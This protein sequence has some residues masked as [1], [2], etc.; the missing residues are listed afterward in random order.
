MDLQQLY[1]L[2]QRYRMQLQGVTAAG[3]DRLLAVG[4]LSGPVGGVAAAGGLHTAPQTV[5]AS[6][7][8]GQKELLPLPAHTATAGDEC[9]AFGPFGALLAGGGGSG[10]RPNALLAHCLERF[11]ADALLAA[12]SARCPPP[13]L[14]PQPQT[15]LQPLTLPLPPAP[16]SHSVRSPLSLPGPVPML[17]PALAAEPNANQTLGLMQY[18][19]AL[20]ARCSQSNDQRVEASK[21]QQMA[22][23]LEG[24]GFSGHSSPLNLS[25]SLNPS[26]STPS[27]TAGSAPSGS[28]KLGSRS[29]I[30]R[31]GE[32]VQVQHDV[33]HKK[34]AASQAAATP[35]SP[36]KIA[37]STQTC[38][39]GATLSK[40]AGVQ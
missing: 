7:V 32:E 18:L 28:E 9:G 14:Q 8:G 29:Y 10:S 31:D 17:L 33:A 1:L 38:K 3:D 6:G 39:L 15:Q 30:H 27:T 21:L 36:H 40:R 25:L 26:S 2:T 16:H 4:G 11:Y 23:E 24:L 5:N 37:H 19:S 13:P 20:C 34:E 35:S 22:Q 12:A